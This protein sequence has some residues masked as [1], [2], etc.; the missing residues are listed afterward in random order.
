[1]LQTVFVYWQRITEALDFESKTSD[2]LTEQFHD[3]LRKIVQS[4]E[5]YMSQKGTNETFLIEFVEVFAMFAPDD[6][7]DIPQE[8][9]F[10]AFLFPLI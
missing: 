7:S 2:S 4:L 6:A 1:M 8:V 5:P 9:S 10:D 3:L